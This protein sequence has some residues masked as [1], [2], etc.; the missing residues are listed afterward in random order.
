MSNICRHRQ[1]IML[2]GSAWPIG[3]SSARSTAG[4]QPRRSADRCAA[5]PDNPASTFSAT[6]SRW[7][8][9]GLLFKGPRSRERRP[10]RNAGGGRTRVQRLQ[11]RS[12]RDPQCN[13]NW[14]T[15]IEVYLGTTTWC[16]ITRGWGSSSPVTTSPGSS[17]VVFGAAVGITSLRSPVRRP[18]SAGTR[19]CSTTMAAR[20]RSVGRSG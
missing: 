19:R 7:T 11:A 18:T 5:F 1:A 14:K 20:C 16:R 3:T 2:Q 12:G 10:G 17:A 13:Y 4:L 8:G 15:F 9:W 6:S